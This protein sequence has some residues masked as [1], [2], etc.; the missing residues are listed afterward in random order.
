[1]PIGSA[2]SW[3]KMN[4]SRPSSTVTGQRAAISSSTG[5]RRHSEA[6]RSPRSTM[7]PSQL[8]YCWSSGRSSPSAR[9]ISARA[10]TM[11]ISSGFIPMYWP[12]IASTIVPGREALQH[13]HQEAGHQD[14]DQRQ[15]QPPYDVSLECAAPRLLLRHA[16]TP[17]FYRATG[18]GC[19]TLGSE[20]RRLLLAWNGV[21]SSNAPGSRREGRSAAA[22][23]PVAAATSGGRC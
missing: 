14:G 5:V 3:L 9:S 23:S 6:P 2:M 7:P 19:T 21:R 4:P 10:A 12:T 16:A 20:P 18:E 8:A 11:S 13:E 22:G 17:P 1:M 15:C